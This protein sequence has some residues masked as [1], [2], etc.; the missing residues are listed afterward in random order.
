[1][2]MRRYLLAIVVLILSACHPAKQRYQGYIQ[3]ELLYLSLP[4]AGAMQDLH[5]RRG[6][7]VQSGDLLFVL[8]PKPQIFESDQA[9]ALL[10]QG[11]ETLE[12]LK[13]P[14]RIP[15]VDAI[16]AQL[17]QVAAQIELAKIRVKRNQILVEKNAGDKDSLD[18]AVEHLRETES[19][20][21]QYTA[22]LAL[23][24]LGARTNQIQA[25]AATNLGLNAS[26]AQA[27]WSLSQKKM[28]A[29][30]Q[31]LIFDTYYKKGEYVQAAQPV[32]SL[33]TRDHT[34]VEFFVPLEKLMVLHIGKPIHFVYGEGGKIMNATIAYIASK[35]EYIP[36]LVYSRDNADKI[37]FRVKASIEGASELIS[38]VPVTVLVDP[39]DERKIV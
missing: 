2:R 34:W 13:K 5:V 18:A 8:D 20:E 35:A 23:A 6:E 37:V 1:M 11:Q 36:P 29:P 17:Q 7:H 28:F 22:N 32:L 4:Y 38:G 26:S 21:A 10:K 39:S 12:D 31:G 33:L 16:K 27:Q 19:L 30:S 24:L 3:G 9:L 14:K 15:E 25:Q